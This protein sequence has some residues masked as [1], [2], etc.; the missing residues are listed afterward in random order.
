MTKTDEDNA[1]KR[2][3]WLMLAS[4]VLFAANILLV[5][6]I[7]QEVPAANGCV[8]TAVR[9]V[10]GLFIV[11]LLYTRSGSIAWK[12]LFSGRLVLA[13]GVVGA[14]GIVAFYIT[15][16][17]LGAARAVLLNLT[18]PIFASVI[19]FC[20]LKEKVSSAAMAWMGTSFAGLM[21]FLSG[22]GEL[23]RVSWYDV[24]ALA[25]AMA[26]GWVVVII[27]RL[28]HEEHFS[29]IFAAQ[30]F[31]GLVLTAPSLVTVPALPN[32]I[33]LGLL[34]AAVLV[35]AGQLLMT[36]GYQLLTVSRGAALQMLLPVATAA[37][38]FCW[39]GESFTLYEGVGAVITLVATW[40]MVVSK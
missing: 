30:A 39:F 28:R 5:R 3:V 26:A 9:S 1:T 4:V 7:S 2:G 38:A 11:A 19:A 36:R 37:G 29:T 23:V 17:Q 10:V 15:V 16:T 27:R 12:R 32:M 6:G 20:W 40:R 34:L 24:L 18:Y 31:Y 35:A 8:T 25:G 22:A 21:I 33:W 14:V 13:R